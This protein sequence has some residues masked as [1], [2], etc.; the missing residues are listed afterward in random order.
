MREAGADGE[1]AIVVSG[2]VV[3]VAASVRTWH[4]TGLLF[5]RPGPRHEATRLVVV[6]W[7]GSE[8]APAAV[9]RNMSADGKSV[10]FVI[11]ADGL[12]W[13]MCDANALCAHASGVNVRSVG[14]EMISRGDDRKVPT[15]GVERPV[16]KEQIHGRPVA[17][18]GFTPAQQLAC[19]ALV[20][21]LC[22]H[23]QLPMRVPMDAAQVRGHALDPNE[24]R[25]FR[26]VIGHL[27]AKQRKNDP[28]LRMLQLLHLHGQS[29][30]HI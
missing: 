13:Q 11:D 3:P 30:S 10:H 22:T 4:E 1:S 2:R 18:A 16:L 25:T 27:H 9:H 7:T 21:A 14:I 24:L 23:Y 19:V 29:P 20:S 8:N 6:H 15:R 28:G 26:G 12:I 5:D 17:Y